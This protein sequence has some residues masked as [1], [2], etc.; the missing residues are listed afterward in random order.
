MS[1]IM[2]R[3]FSLIKNTII[4]SIGKICTQFISFFLLPLYTSLLTTEEYGIVDLLNTLVSLLLPIITFQIEQGVFRELIDNRED[5]FEIKKII[6]TSIF[7][8]LLQ[9]ILFTLIFL[10]IL[11]FINNQYKIYLF[12]NVIITVFA[13][14]FLQISRGLGENIIYSFASFI[15]SFITIMGNIIFLVF[16]DMK[17]EGMLLSTFLGQFSCILIIFYFL[18]LYKK[19]DYKMFKKTIYKKILR[20][21]LPLVPNAISWWV[22]TASDRVIVSM[23]L[24]AS[25]NGLLSASSKFSSIIV[26]VFNILNIS[27]TESISKNINDSDAKDYF[28]KM[29]NLFIRFF[30]SIS[31]II[32]ASMNI[33]Y[34]I[35]VNSNYIEGI[36]LT[37]FLVLASF[38]NIY[39]S[40]IG[41]IY[42]AKKNTK[43]IASI[44]FISAILNIIIHLILINFIGLYAAPI[45]S[46][47]AYLILI[48]IR[49]KDVKIRYFKIKLNR[50][51]YFS[52]LLL[53]PITLFIFYLGNNLINISYLCILLI[54][55]FILNFK[56]ILLLKTLFCKLFK[57][58]ISKN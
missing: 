29:F 5:I 39:L 20:Y 42:I 35:M 3:E 46:L 44:S 25:S 32:I 57:K 27:W 22:F 33:I 56:Y 41:S 23:F 53:I 54:K 17:V 48:F 6:S 24:G 47:I 31:L 58:V 4:I 21:S 34:P 18:R 2:N 43:A 16:F 7:S 1:I 55:I 19:I 28:N 11:P 40:L 15:S 14:L 8:V 52:I 49:T 26:M 9:C 45:S 51:N 10:I 36:K 38:F 30:L 50:I 13:S 12:G 37:P